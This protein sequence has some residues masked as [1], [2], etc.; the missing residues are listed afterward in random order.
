MTDE[1]TSSARPDS[2]FDK[3]AVPI[4][5]YEVLR[6]HRRYFIGVCIRGVKREL[7]ARIL[8][9]CHK[10]FKGLFA[11]R[12]FENRK[13]RRRSSVV[14]AVVPARRNDG[15]FVHARILNRL[16]KF[17]GYAEREMHDYLLLVFLRINNRL[18]G[19]R[20]RGVRL[21]SH[22]HRIAKVVEFRKILDSLLY[23][24]YRTPLYLVFLIAPRHCGIIVLSRFKHI[25]IQNYVV[26]K[27]AEPF[28]HVGYFI[29][30]KNRIAAVP[31]LDAKI[32]I[33]TEGFGMRPKCFRFCFH[34]ENRHYASGNGIDPVFG[35]EVSVYAAAV[36]PIAFV[37]F[38]GAGEIG[39]NVD[40]FHVVP[41]CLL[42]YGKPL[43]FL[44]DIFKRRNLRR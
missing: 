17:F 6:P 36:Y 30:E 1:K 25:K 26:V 32:V 7:I 5:R 21:N 37:A 4:F 8:R 10:P 9:L 40:I 38:V 42:F 2:A 13:M 35:V 28:A 16:H 41:D 34:A 33:E 22:N 19:Y 3:R 23:R 18:V 20:L 43:R 44:G 11:A 24:F 39:Y 12:S 27:V 15:A 29:S 14:S 31:D